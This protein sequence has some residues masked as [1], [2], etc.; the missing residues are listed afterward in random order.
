MARDVSMSSLRQSMEEY[1]SMRRRLGFKLHEAGLRL[2]DFV[3]FMEE[4]RAHRITSALAL[5][6]A[7]KSRDVQP[8]IWAQ[9]LGVV[10]DFARYLSAFDP[11]TEVPAAELLPHRYRR[12]APYLYTDQEVRRILAATLELYPPSGLGR[13]TYHTL[14]GLLSATGM[15]PGEAL[16]LELQDID[17]KQCVLTVRGS[18]FGKSRWVVIHPSTR[19]ALSQYLRRRERCVAG[20]AKTHVFLTT[21]GTNLREGS[22]VSTFRRLTHKIGLCSSRTQRNPRLIDFRHRFAVRTLVSFYR[23]G[24]DPQRWLPVLSTHL[25]HAWTKET[26]WYIEQHPDLMRQAMKRLERRWKEAS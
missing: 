11:R 5:T 26:Y 7:Q 14:I 2:K 25:G 15:R 17:L 10:R 24:K 16:N 18:K 8:V 19:D 12:R 3:S 23:S 6:W 22:A 1:L 21:Q 4:R 13:W 9:R 20:R